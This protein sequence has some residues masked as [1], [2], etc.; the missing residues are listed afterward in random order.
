[1]PVL[2]SLLLCLRS[3]FRE[4]AELHAEI[5]ALRHQLLILQR[6]NRNHRLGL[7]RPT[8]R[9]GYGSPAFGLVGALLS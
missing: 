7:M 9:S 5:L 4:R 3:F 8:V 6:G 1:M 2:F